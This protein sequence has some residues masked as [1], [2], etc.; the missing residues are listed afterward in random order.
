MRPI[1]THA[2]ADSR[3]ESLAMHEVLPQLFTSDPNCFSGHCPDLLYNREARKVGS[4]KTM[5]PLPSFSSHVI[6]ALMQISACNVPVPSG[7][8]HIPYS[9]R[10]LVIRQSQPHG[11]Y[12]TLSTYPESCLKD[13]ALSGLIYLCSKHGR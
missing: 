10:S 9:C 2:R 3:F 8:T 13:G 11:L 5:P 6:M 1:T 4:Q 7:A 12:L